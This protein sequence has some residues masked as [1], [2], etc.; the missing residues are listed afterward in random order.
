MFNKFIVFTQEMSDQLPQE[1]DFELEAKNIKRSQ[2]EL[3]NFKA[4]SSLSTVDFQSD[5]YIPSAYNNLTTQKVIVM[6]YMDG[7]KISDPKTMLKKGINL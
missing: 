1:L 3:K 6:E 7:L 4:S 5:V 2:Q